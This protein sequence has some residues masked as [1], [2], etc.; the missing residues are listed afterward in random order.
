[1]SNL[2]RG[3]LGRG[4]GQRRERHAGQR[5]PTHH[6]VHRH[7]VFGKCNWFYRREH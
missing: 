1:M 5:V 3:L 7:D 4:R 6:S 2:L